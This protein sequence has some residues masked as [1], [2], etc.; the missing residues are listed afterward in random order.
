[1]WC[2][3][4]SM[5]NQGR[6]LLYEREFKMGNIIIGVILLVIAFFAVRA[7]IKHFKGQGSCCGGSDKPEKKKL[8]GKV[9]KTYD[10]KVEDMHC[11]NCV[12]SVTNTINSV[13][14]AVGTVSLGKKSAKI[15]CDREID[16]DALKLKLHQKGYE[17]V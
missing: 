12:N 2:L 3:V 10:F 4:K 14:G 7:S 5:G 11:Q 9:V 6:R 15:S 8:D 16:L 17:L 1:M 13:E